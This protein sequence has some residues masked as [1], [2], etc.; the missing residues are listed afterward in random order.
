M[1]ETCH[2]GLASIAR[3]DDSSLRAALKQSLAQMP[4]KP[5]QSIEGAQKQSETKASRK[6]SR[7]KPAA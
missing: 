3:S 1:E 6:G 7:R 2:D 4:K 5:P